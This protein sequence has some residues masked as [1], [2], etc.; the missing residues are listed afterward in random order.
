MPDLETRLERVG[1]TRKQAID[2]VDAHARV[3]KLYELERYI[4]VK[5]A[6][7]EVLG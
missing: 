7:L 4:Q 1:Y 3:G 6:V 2:A 5:E